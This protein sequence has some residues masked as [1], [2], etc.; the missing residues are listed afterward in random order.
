MSRHL[1]LFALA[2]AMVPS[3]LA[4]GLNCICEFSG[5]FVPYQRCTLH[6]SSLMG[7]FA[8]ILV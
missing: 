6:H 8:I 7:I 4:I 1:P 2:S 5:A 3:H